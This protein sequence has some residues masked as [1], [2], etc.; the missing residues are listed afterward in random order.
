MYYKM[1]AL[2]SILIWSHF[3][4]EDTTYAKMCMLYLAIAYLFGFLCV[5]ACTS[6]QAIGSVLNKELVSSTDRRF[7]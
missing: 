5:C 2:L 4:Y 6:F 7:L 3:Q 1:Q